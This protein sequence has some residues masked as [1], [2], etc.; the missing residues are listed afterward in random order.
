MRGEFNGYY[1]IMISLHVLKYKKSC[2]TH[3]GINFCE[4][5]SLPVQGRA[6]ALTLVSS[7]A[8]KLALASVLMLLYY[9][10]LCDGQGA[11]R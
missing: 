8:A 1:G 6:I 10:V 9:S 5:F 2:C 11:D 4:L 7:L 3:F